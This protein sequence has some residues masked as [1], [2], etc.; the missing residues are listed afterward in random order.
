MA[1]LPG[2][3]EPDEI[4]APVR[5]YRSTQPVSY[6]AAEAFM[7]ERAARIA[8]GSQSELLWFLEHPSLYTAGTSARIGDLVEPERFP[9]HKTGRG[10]QYTYHGPGQRIAYVM[11]DLRRRS[12]SD[13]RRFVSMLH[14]WIIASLAA[15]EI[16]GTERHGRVGVW[17][18]RKTDGPLSAARDDKIAAV[19]LRLYRWVSFHGVSLNVSV[20]LSHYDGIVPCGVREHGVTSLS[21][22][23]CDARMEQVDQVL[24]AAFRQT[25]EVSL[26]SVDC[27]DDVRR[28]V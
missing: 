2:I 1:R 14:A 23:G 7:R 6:E 11:L 24:L 16:E 5:W 22:L 26:G 9:V 3:D 19:G 4:A 28:F 25:F 20:D 21:A 8:R 18:E 10:G 13:V 27:T 17:V 12:A 15:L